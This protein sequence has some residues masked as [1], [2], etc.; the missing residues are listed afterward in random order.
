MWRRLLWT[1]MLSRLVEIQSGLVP[2][3]DRPGK[4]FFTDILSKVLRTSRAND[5]LLILRDSLLDGR[6]NDIL[7][8][9]AAATAQRVP[10][11]Y[12]NA[13]RMEPEFRVSS[14]AMSR[15]LVVYIYVSGRGPDIVESELV[16]EDTERFIHDRVRPKVLVLMILR[17]PCHDLAALFRAMWSKKILDAIVVEYFK[18]QYTDKYSTIVHRYN[19]F[20]DTHTEQPYSTDITWFTD[21]F[22]NMQGYPLVYAFTRRPPYSDIVSTSKG[23]ELKGVDKFLCEVL[24]DKMNFTGVPKI[25]TEA[26]Y[27][28]KMPN[29]SQYGIMPDIASGK[30]DAL[31]IS[32]P[33]WGNNLKVRY[34]VQYTDPLFI[35]NWCFVVPKLLVKQNFLAGTAIR[36]VVMNF[37]IVGIFWL[38]SRF[39]KFNPGR[40]HFFR[41]VGI[42]LAASF[43]SSPTKLHERIIFLCILAVSA[44]YSSMLFAE[45]TSI[46]FEGDRY[47]QFDHL[48]NLTS[49]DLVLMVHENILDIIKLHSSDF[50]YHVRK[51]GKT[52]VRIRSADICLKDLVMHQNVSCFLYEDRVKLITVNN[53]RNGETMMKMTK[54]CYLS[55][56]VGN[57][58]SEGSPYVKRVSDLRL[59]LA[60]AGIRDK[61]YREYL[62][63]ET[64]ETVFQVNRDHVDFKYVSVFHPTI[65]VLIM[66]YSMSAFVFIGELIWKYFYTNL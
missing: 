42:I 48:Q 64:K 58:F 31:L 62:R 33:L 56:A 8:K 7:G 53:M 28:Q 5:V 9:I 3:N 6:A 46:G 25:I 43:P 26:V 30:Y 11:L 14:W 50:E 51:S 40:W 22:P 27:F 45:L 60:S 24:A 37:S 38:C 12:V 10:T 23:Q 20:T 57:V 41:I 44:S 21:E 52:V 63:N 39:M 66:G 61:W 34:T 16:A 54:L 2:P 49:S 29:G 47:V 1:I 36:L 13:D 4:D 32:M 18:S 65:Y 55:P 59:M 17:R 19:P 15:D 35:E